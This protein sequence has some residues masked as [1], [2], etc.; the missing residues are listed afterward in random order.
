LITESAKMPSI[1]EMA[2]K[3]APIVYHAS[4]EPNLPAN[5]DWFLDRTSLWFYDRNCDPP[6]KQKLI[7]RPSQED[8]VQQSYGPSCGTASTVHSGGTRSTS[9][10]RTFF[11]EDVAEGDRKG[12]VDPSDW[13]TYFHA[14]PNVN[15]GVTIQYWRFH[16]YNSGLRIDVVDFLERL[17]KVILKRLGLESVRDIKIGF[18]GGDWE[19]IHVVLDAHSNPSMVRLLGHTGIQRLP[20]DS[21]PKQEGSHPIVY[22]EK[23]G[24]ATLAKDSEAGFQQATGI[25]HKTWEVGGIV[26]LGEKTAPLNG[27]VFVQ[28]SGLWGT[29]ST[30]PKGLPLVPSDIVQKGFC[31]SSGYW[32]PAFNE[33]ELR[34]DNFVTAWGEGTTDEGKVVDG[35]PEYRP[36]D[37]IA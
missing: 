5:V 24:H 14:H 27:Q 8:L 15:D 6:L 28:Y 30:L 32:G 34:S 31:V 11:L 26:N 3:F 25:Q 7:E 4:D 21:I 20:W 1:Q 10:W 19:G 22:S 33:T 17:P 36:T 18:H 23:R 13:T 2:Q 12:C 35:V 16:A 29:P 37:P 9:K